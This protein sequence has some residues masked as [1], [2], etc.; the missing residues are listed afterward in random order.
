VKETQAMLSRRSA[1]RLVLAGRRAA[2][3]VAAWLIA[4]GALCSRP[5]FDVPRPLSA[6]QGQCNGRCLN[7]HPGEFKTWNGQVNGCQVQVWRQWPDGC[8]H[9]QWYDSCNGSWDTDPA[10]N[11]RVTWT[12]CVH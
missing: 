4:A 9:A 3:C 12:C 7:P 8:L 10:G 11:P 1:F 6:V 2:F 5:A